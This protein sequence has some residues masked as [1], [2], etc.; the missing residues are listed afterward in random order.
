MYIYSMFSLS[1]LLLTPIFTWAQSPVVSLPLSSGD[2]LSFAY[3]P[4][5]TLL[6]G[7]PETELGRDSDEAPRQ[8]IRFQRGF[9]LG[10]YE[11]TQAQWLA[12][13]G[14]NPAIFQQSPDHL[15]HPIE[16]VSW[17]DCQLFIERLN[18]LGIGF[19]RLPTEAEWEY[20]CRAG[21]TSRYYWGDDSEGWQSHQ[22]G[23]INSRSMATPHPV[24]QKKPNAWGLYDMSGNV[25]EWCSD[26][27]APYGQTPKHDSL[28]VFR[29]GSWYDFVKSQRSA[30]RH[31]H[32]WNERFPAIGL[33]LV[34]EKEVRQIPLPG[35][36]T[37]NI[38]RIPAGNFVMGS[39][40]SEVFFQQDE[41]PA[42]PVSISQDFWL[43]QF[44]VTQTQWEAVMGKN[45]SV[46]HRGQDADE[47]PVDMV[48]WDDCQVFI[49]KLNA[50]GPGTFRL[51]TEAEWEYACRAGTSTLYPWGESLK[52]SPIRD[53]AWFNS[54]AEGVSH[55]VGE[56][57]PNPWGLY[58][59]HGNVWEWC[60]DWRGPYSP[61]P[62]TDPKGP[63]SGKRKVYRGG[64]WFNE[65]EALR[66]ANRHGHPP[67]ERFT[68]AGLRLVW[69][70]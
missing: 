69:Q 23:W 13:M 60:Q 55:P 56:K 21:T 25:W 57:L 49:G 35:R 36:E 42:H 64:S 10:T 47:R 66:S 68:N 50:L 37:M 34:L 63:A 7:S 70:P 18:T 40:S 30:N 44:E 5:G 53:Y 11:I 52:L 3:L 46:F 54:R 6:M 1:M 48:S 45:P 38:V 22:Y 51:P 67:T 58:D 8:E 27:Y 61:A 14:T 39:D 4:G 26:T 9:Y 16:S 17:N 24:G 33:R 15:Q 28:K 43:G 62:Q 31:K 65:P 2:S 32:G 41:L 29:G 20:A 12:I 59:M 19:F